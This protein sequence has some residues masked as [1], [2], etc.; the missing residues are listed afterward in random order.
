MYFF[1]NKRKKVKDE[2][3]GLITKTIKNKTENN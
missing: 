3:Q 1:L 2:L